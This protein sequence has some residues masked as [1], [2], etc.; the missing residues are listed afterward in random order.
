[1]RV[2]ARP[3]LALACGLVA[4]G[5]SPSIAASRSD[6][7]YTFSITT[8]GDR[9]TASGRGAIQLT[10]DGRDVASL[11]PDGELT[12]MQGTWLRRMF[13]GGERTLVLRT[14]ADGRLER[15]FLVSGAPRPYEP[16]GA[17]WMA[18]SLP[19][20]LDAGFAA[21]ERVEQLLQAS[22]VEGVLRVIPEL[23]S[24]HLQATYFG[25]LLDHR[26]A[27]GSL[28]AI[29]ALA[30]REMTSDYEMSRLLVRAA[31]A[32]VQDVSAQ[33]PFFDA[34]ATISSDY[35]H[36][37]VLAAVVRRPDLPSAVLGAALRAAAGID[38]DYEMAQLLH[39]VVASHSIEEVREPFFAAAASISAD[40]EHARV[41]GAIVNTG[42]PGDE[43]LT[44]LLQS[45]MGIQSDHELSQLLVRVAAL[46]PLG[47]PLHERYLAAVRTLSAE[48][49]RTRA[50]AALVERQPG[51]QS[52]RKP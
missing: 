8:H 2:P 10:V 37:R 43:T 1:M 12:L 36:H 32:L 6:P 18:Q 41:L 23:R 19:R 44:A 13:L 49:E 48:H 20:L 14:A 29:L 30:A 38:S 15:E 16:E 25:H 5:C 17:A 51:A 42:R 33:R 45:A 9:L 26:D 31:D 34:V 46:G 39:A 35:E 40:H 50:L 21:R 27:S 28:D 3:A 7:E 4:A 52:S 24:D 22:G 11:G 47:A